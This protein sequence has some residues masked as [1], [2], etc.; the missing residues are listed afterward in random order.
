MLAAANAWR[1]LASEL[2]QTAAGYASTAA[3]IPW[4]GPSATAMTLSTLPYIAWLHT[5]AGQAAQMSL[6][7]T[8]M[9]SSFVATQT[10]VVHPSVVTANRSDDVK[11]R[12]L[13]EPFDVI[14]MNGK[15]PS[16]W[17]AKEASLWIKQNCPEM[18]RHILFTF[19]HGVEQGTE[20]AFLQ[21]NNIPFL[22]K[23]FEVAELISHARRLLQKAH[24]AAASA[25]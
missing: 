14:I 24:A 16:D 5:T 20:R 2:G 23:P 13:S 19:S 11:T 17:N 12:L 15:M 7:A 1:Q 9:A 21:E 3:G 8:T 6:A 25:N 22:V 10:A 4:Q 18:E